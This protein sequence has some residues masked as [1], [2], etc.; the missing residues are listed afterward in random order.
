METTQPIAGTTFY[1]FQETPPK[2][3]QIGGIYTTDKDG[4]I[5]V[6]LPSGNYYF[7]EVAPSIGYTFDKDADGKEIRRYHFTVTAFSTNELPIVT[8]YNQRQLGRLEIEKEIKN[9]TGDEL[10][11]EQ[12]KE[13]FE[14]KVTFSDGESYFYQID[15]GKKQL[16]ESGGTLSLKHG[17]KAVFKKIPI[18]VH[19]LV[20]EIPVEG[21][22]SFGDNT[23][24][25]IS[26]EGSTVQFVNYYIPTDD[27]PNIG[28]RLEISK[29]VTNGDGS[30]LTEEQKQESFEFV[31]TFSDPL[32]E[33]NFFTST[34][35]EGSLKSGD[36][37]TLNHD[38]VLTITNLPIGTD[39]Q[40]KEKENKD[41][42]SSPSMYTGT[43][44]ST[45][46]IFLS[47]TNQYKTQ[48]DEFGSL[49]FEKKVVANQINQ[50]QK[51]TFILTFSDGG[52]YD[53]RLND[54][55]LQLHRSGDKIELTHEDQI[56]FPELPAGLHYQLKE[57]VAE[58]YQPQLEKVE[59]TILSNH[60]A[61]FLFHNY[62]DE[63]GQLVIHKIGE[64]EGFNPN[65]SFSFKVW[66]NDQL[67]P[68]SIQLKS[69]ETSVPIQLS[70]GDHWLVVED[71][72]FDEGYL[73]G[74]I[75]NGTGVV[76]EPG[77]KVTVVQT[78]VFIKELMITLK[79]QKHWSIKEGQDVSLPNS[80]TVNLKDG[81]KVVATKKVTG[82]DWRYEF[83]VPK[84]N[85]QGKEIKYTIEELPVDQFRPIYHPDSIDITNVYV[86]PVVSRA[87]PVKK[88]ITGDIPEKKETFEFRL[89]P[90]KQVVTIEGEGTGAF[91]PITFNQPGIYIY[92]ISE[93]NK[94]TLGYQY[95][96]S[97][98]TWTIVVEE[99]EQRLVIVS[100]KLMK[101]GKAY[102]EDMP[103]FENRFSKDKL[104]HEKITIS[105]KK[106]WNFGSQLKEERPSS[107]T[108]LLRANEKVVYQKEVG[109]AENWSYS[110]TLNRYDQEG[111][112]IHYSVDEVPVPGYKKT[113][114]GFDLINT[115][116]GFPNTKADVDKPSWLPKTG[117]KK[118]FILVVLGGLFMSIGLIIVLSRRYRKH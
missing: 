35:K 105:G 24:G 118:S 8:A 109:A 92:S 65:K 71:D 3:T 68:E 91:A 15:N 73:Q 9:P 110:F 40:V 61:Y 70:I 79:G 39:Y 55:K 83:T 69:G 85:E 30:N 77:Q 47:F 1:L 32:A 46:T 18:G 75:L 20:E 89:A 63:R 76:T 103:I 42:T 117:E 7:E 62:Q 34:D 57:E 95:D 97:V 25:N 52:S 87:L 111:N 5:S 88:R 48:L 59:G 38:E 44:Q 100:E 99:K 21:Y 101:D 80:I 72:I 108:V 17:Q 36:T 96:P 4:K 49:R 60:E 13:S 90:G 41:Y 28:G 45:E 12:R 54:G 43:V 19:Y 11:L 14:F 26:E 78:N 64:G 74:T 66:I 2:D 94:G 93:R 33:F 56:Y 37:F 67:L 116:E 104:I 6:K 58:G 31:I 22:D 23:S 112:V 86:V 81:D 16:L 115:Y 102:L 51:F 10:T 106:K 107:I 98:Y 114:E 82:P 50:E 27:R 53:Y 84:Y 113:V 29:E